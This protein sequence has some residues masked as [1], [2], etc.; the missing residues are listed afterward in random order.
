MQVLILIY[1]FLN[2]TLY[3]SDQFLKLLYFY[4]IN[5]IHIFSYIIS[6]VV[7]LAYQNKQ[8]NPPIFTNRRTTVAP[9]GMSDIVNQHI[10]R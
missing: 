6:L 3:Q 9:P 4:K 7:K 2:G 8:D 1:F 10:L 5:I